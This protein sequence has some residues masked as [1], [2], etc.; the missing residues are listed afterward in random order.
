MPEKRFSLHEI[1]EDLGLE[2]YT[3][4]QPLVDELQ[5]GNFAAAEGKPAK[6]R[7]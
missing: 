2:R 6:V 7:L 5:T 1:H 4:M 3:Q